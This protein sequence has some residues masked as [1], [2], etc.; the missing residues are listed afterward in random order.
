MARHLKDL[1]AQLESKPQSNSSMEIF[2]AAH[3]RKSHKEN[4]IQI[5]F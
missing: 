4:G 3:V 5:T 1:G 2:E